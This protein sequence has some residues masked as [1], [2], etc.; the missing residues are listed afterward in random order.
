MNKR[1]QR[2]Q[3]DEIFKDV[4]QLDPFPAPARGWLRAI[5]ESLGMP[6]RELADRIGTSPQAIQQIEK[7]EANQSITIASLKS[8]VET[9]DCVFLYAIVP[10]RPLEETMRKVAEEAADKII[11]GATQ[12]MDLEGQPIRMAPMETTREE[13]ILE[14]ENNPRLIWRLV[15]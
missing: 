5:R 13:L 10:K 3:L 11:K 4:R 14:L 12:T 8:A 6:L 15:K 9:L 1:T 2:K 7:R